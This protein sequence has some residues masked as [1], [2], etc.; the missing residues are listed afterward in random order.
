MNAE[1]EKYYNEL[2]KAY[3]SGELYFS[4]NSD[5]LHN[6]AIML[7]MLEKGKRISM[8]CGSMSV[9]KNDFYT[10]VLDDDGNPD[11]DIKKK[12]SDAFTNFISKD[13][14]QINIIL[15]R[16]PDNLTD[17]LIFDKDLLQKESV[18]IYQI[19]EVIRERAG[20]NHYSFIDNSEITR[21][22]S[23]A[24]NHTALCKIGNAPDI[25]SPE[26]SFKK[27]RELSHRVTI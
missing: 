19:P 27:L 18:A 20:I 26:D 5:H 13:G 4:R 25:E 3:D 15:E 14:N 6:A 7:L 24:V 11:M 1:F 21:I 12:V 22:E 9:F 17:G 23:D 16:K 2:A 8:F 10:Y